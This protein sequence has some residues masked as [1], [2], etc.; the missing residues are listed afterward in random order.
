M[1]A[2]RHVA[3]LRGIN[4]GKA[5]RIAMADLRALFERLGH[6]DVRTLLNSGNVVFTPAGRPAADA[7]RI[8]AAILDELGVDAP[9][10][11]LSG[12]VLAAA[13]AANPLKQGAEDPAHLLLAVVRDAKAMSRIRPLARERWAPEAIAVGKGVV[14]LWCA[15]GLA[16]PG[17]WAAV[18]RA[19]GEDVTARNLSTLGKLLALV[20]AD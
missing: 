10:T 9:V 11:V 16:G 17:L 8:R 15:K 1:S 6:R 13:V 2:D 12:R 14:Y 20:E 5:K 19:G 3:L 7:G 18:N 4:V